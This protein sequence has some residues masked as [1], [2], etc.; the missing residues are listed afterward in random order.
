MTSALERWLQIWTSTNETTA[1]QY[2]QLLHS[3]GVL[4][5]IEV[6]DAFFRMATE[7]CIDSCYK[8]IVQSAAGTQAGCS[9]EAAPPRDTDSLRCD[10][11]SRHQKFE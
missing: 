3:Y 11:S 10:Q 8:T 7:I 5:T 4:K 9:I 1:G 6:A 2:L